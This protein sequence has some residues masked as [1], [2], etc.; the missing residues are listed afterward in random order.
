MYKVL[1]ISPKE[2][3]AKGARKSDK[4]AKKEEDESQPYAS[5][6]CLECV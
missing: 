5:F 3:G 1:F 6:D 2:H 4:I